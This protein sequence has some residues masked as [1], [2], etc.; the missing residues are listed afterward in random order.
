LQQKRKG[1][2]DEYEIYI[3]GL[4]MPRGRLYKS[5]NERVEKMFQKGVIDEVNRLKGVK[6]GRTAS[7]AIGLR[8]IK[9]YLEGSLSL[10]EA[11]ELMKKNTRNYAKRQM[12][13]FRKAGYIK[14][15]KVGAGEGAGSVALK[16]LRKIR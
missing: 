9:G 11:K 15:I 7:Y 14:W 8:E 5:I 10:E 4:D 12:T 16:I 6:L 13:W 2:K 1:L 3:F